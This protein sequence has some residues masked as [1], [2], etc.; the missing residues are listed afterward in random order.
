VRAITKRQE[1][2]SLTAYRKTPD[3]DYGGY[4]VK[5]ELRRSLVTEQRG[6][7]CYCMS[8]IRP[9]RDP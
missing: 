6:L 3:S 9:E 5:D 4:P 8:R 2:A 7:C 1:P